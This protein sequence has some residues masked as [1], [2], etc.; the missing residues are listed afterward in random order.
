[1]HWLDG[2][3]HVS[4]DSQH[5]RNV[6]FDYGSPQC[7]PDTHSPISVSNPLV[8]LSGEIGDERIGALRSITHY[9]PELVQSFSK[10]RSYIQAEASYRKLLVSLS[11]IKQKLIG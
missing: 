9:L 11:S 2:V 5:L 6:A 10:G 7:L 8:R 4:T 3:L 1:M